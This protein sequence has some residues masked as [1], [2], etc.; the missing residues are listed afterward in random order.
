MRADARRNQERIFAEARRAVAEGDTSLTLNELA[1]RAGVGVGTV[2]RQF[3][4]QQAMLEA[5]AE[6]SLDDLIA[7]AV[8]AREAPDAATGL[9]GF[10][11]TA[12]ERSVSEPGLVDVLVTADDETPSTS[13][14]K[15]EL[16]ATVSALLDRARSEGITRLP[17]TGEELLKLLCGVQHAITAAHDG[18]AAAR[19][20]LD[21]MLTGLGLATR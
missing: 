18:Q 3:P 6:S 21:L 14:R 15:A 17:L 20:Y 4:T 1:R 5:V 19:N 10:L 11:R 7:L 12:L 8:S 2:Y 9:D 16:A 13:A